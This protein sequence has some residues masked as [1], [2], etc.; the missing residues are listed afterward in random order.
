M[1]EFVSCTLHFAL[2][3]FLLL[4]A[5]EVML[6]GFLCVHLRLIYK[7]TKGPVAKAMQFA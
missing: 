2:I 1:H 4:M 7:L 5:F 3:S 6:A